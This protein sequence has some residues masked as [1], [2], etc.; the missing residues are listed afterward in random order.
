MSGIKDLFED[1]IGVLKQGEKSKDHHM[2]YKTIN[3][4]ELKRED[5]RSDSI[6]VDSEYANEF[7]ADPD[8][9]QG[10]D[11]DVIVEIPVNQL[12]HRLD[13]L[14]ETGR[15]YTICEV[16][17]SDG[18]TYTGLAYIR[19][20]DNFPYNIDV[21]DEGLRV[22][23]PLHSM[24]NF[25]HSLSTIKNSLGKKRSEVYPLKIKVHIDPLIE[26][27]KEYESPS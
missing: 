6:W 10:L 20:Y 23:V 18:S 1:E 7:G 13:T 27:S 11:E 9:L 2:Y 22:H 4:F 3:L 5:L 24:V 19:A 12:T 16:C 15:Y 17:F 25:E 14:R 8:L 21:F 26:I